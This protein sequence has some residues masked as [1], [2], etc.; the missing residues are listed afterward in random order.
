MPSPRLY[1]RINFVAISNSQIP[2]KPHATFGHQAFIV[3][4]T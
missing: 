1:I 4:L 2:I 3:A